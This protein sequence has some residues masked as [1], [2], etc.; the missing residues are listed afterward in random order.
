MTE[1]LTPEER[2]NIALI[3]KFIE[4]KA[5]FYCSQYFVFK[6]FLKSRFST[7]EKMLEYFDVS[8]A[9]IGCEQE[10]KDK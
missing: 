3:A 7:R 9:D 6:E 10:S 1:K 8:E 5:E 2:K 4:L